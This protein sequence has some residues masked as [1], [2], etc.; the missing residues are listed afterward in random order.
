MNH[1]AW[2]IVPSPENGY[3]SLTAHLTDQQPFLAIAGQLLGPIRKPP[4]TRNNLFLLYLWH[5]S[6]LVQAD[7]APVTSRFWSKISVCGVCEIQSRSR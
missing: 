2:A 1:F 4:S 3:K 6:R 7:Q 5:T